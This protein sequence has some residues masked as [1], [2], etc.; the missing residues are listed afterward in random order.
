MS[1]QAQNSP[2]PR[3][4]PPG[5]PTVPAGGMKRVLFVDDENKV[6]EGLQRMLYPMRGEWR[7]E[8]VSSGVE[9]LRRLSESEFDVLVTDIRM[10]VMSGIELLNQV[11]ELHPQVVRLVLSGTVSMD[12]TLRS[13]ALAHQYLVKPCD[14]A[15]LRSKVEHALNLR[16]MLADPALKQLISRLP[17]LPSVPS[18]YTR[19]LQALRSAEVSTKDIGLI[20][21]QDMA[22]TAKILQLANSA[23]LG[24]ARRVATPGEAVTYLGVDAVRSLVLSASVFSQFRPKNLQEFSVEALQE[25]SLKVAALAG[26]IAHSLTWSQSA[27]NDTFVGGLLH[28]AGKLVLA[29]H[30]P[31][32]YRTALLR[33]HGGGA[34]I[35]EAEQEVFGTTHAEVG[36]YLLWLWGIPDEITEVAATHHRRPVDPERPASPADAVH[37]AD[38]LVNQ[39]IDQDLDRAR[40]ENLGWTKLLP[41]WQERWASLAA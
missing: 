17:N 6:L 7:M 11:V 40:V 27:M 32:A 24:L 29:Q 13:A 23:F 34:S 22:M 18:I 25:H 3:I 30:C 31:D 20:I 2:T 33:A 38:A 35:R 41:E 10:P 39:R 36:G 26:E 4:A 8:F 28:D 19:L 5:A 21:E 16:T 1:A 12:L 14:A 15:T 37:V 9:A